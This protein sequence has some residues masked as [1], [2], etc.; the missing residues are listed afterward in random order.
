LVAGD[1]QV[2]RSAIPGASART[3]FR[4][5]RMVENVNRVEDRA[6]LDRRSCYGKTS[7][8]SDLGAVERLSGL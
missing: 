5:L 8:Y 4:T 2:R 3:R 7:A 6:I 1:T